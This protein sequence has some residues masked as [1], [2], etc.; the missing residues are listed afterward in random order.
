M[1][2]YGAMLVRS[3]IVSKNFN[4]NSAAGL[5]KKSGSPPNYFVFNEVD[6]IE[7]SLKV[8]KDIC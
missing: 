1:P 7:E 6:N 4:R 5:L 8:T 2:N 3:E